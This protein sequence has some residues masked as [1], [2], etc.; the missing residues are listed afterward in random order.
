MSCGD[1]TTPC[2]EVL[3]ELWLYLDH[4]CDEKRREVLQRHLDECGRCLEHF[5]IE[6]HLK[7][8]LARKCGNEQAS[9][10][11]K[12]RL[13]ASIRETVLAQAE[14]TVEPAAGGARTVE[15]TLTNQRVD[16]E[17]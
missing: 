1:A 5:G 10:D 4:E 11:F 6:E 13:R 12:E 3:G 9:A 14:V 15:V 2:H 17:A 8:L 16:E 7:E